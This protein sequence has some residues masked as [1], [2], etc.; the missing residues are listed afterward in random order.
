MIVSEVGNAPQV[1]SEL[2]GWI[3]EVTIIGTI[4][5]LGWK[6]RGIWQGVVDFSTRITKHMDLME[7][8]A[9]NVVNNH[10]KHIERDL[11]KMAGRTI[12]DE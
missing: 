3:R 2:L 9:G 1:I 12:E 4:M 5:V 10:L 8:F 7:E 6:S 11:A